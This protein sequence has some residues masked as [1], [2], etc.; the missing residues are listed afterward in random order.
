MITKHNELHARIAE[1]EAELENMTTQN[2]IN[3][4]VINEIEAQ[5]A[6]AQAYIKEALDALRWVTER[7]GR[8]RLDDCVF[9][10]ID[11]SKE[12]SWAE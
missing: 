6:E 12:L 3:V 10:A 11:K 7:I 8:N 1:L 4:D 5:L 2:N 9:D